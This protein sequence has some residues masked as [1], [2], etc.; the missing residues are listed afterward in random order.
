MLA[1]IADM[2][3]AI[4]PERSIMGERKSLWRRLPA[5]L[6]RAEILHVLEEHNETACR[7]LAAHKDAPPEALYYLASEGSPAVRRAVAANLSAPAH[8][9]RHLA[10]DKDDE[11]RVELARKIGQL[12]PK[13]PPEYTKRMRDLT[14]ETLER[15]ARDTLPRVRQALAEEIKALDCLPPRIVKALARDVEEVAAPIL[16]YSPLLSDSDLIEIISSAQASFALVAIAKRRP[17]RAGVT[18]AIATALDVPAVAAM[19]LNSSAKIRHQTLDKIAQQAE[20]VRDWQAPLVFRDEIPQRV[21]RRLAGFVSKAL[22]EALAAKHNLD[23]KTKQYLKE[24]LK[25]R[26]ESNEAI[27]A[28]SGSGK[29]DLVALKKAGKLDDA[30]VEAAVEHGARDIVIASLVLLTGLAPETV[31]RIFQTGSAKAV[32]SVVWRAGLSM[33]IAFKIQTLLLRLPSDELLP[34]RDGIRFPMAEQE[35]RWH[36][37]YFR[38]GA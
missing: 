22:I 29:N 14:I 3:R 20:R 36:L 11:V 28:K 9:N 37:E 27:L 34:A 25:Q 7:E 13:L 18:D 19:L 8:A 31:A 35:M 32:T 30:F 38:T 16:E 1:R 33:R 17:L 6:N 2:G 21:V 15:L 12:L 26:F 5:L 10:E 24:K 4:P 23:D